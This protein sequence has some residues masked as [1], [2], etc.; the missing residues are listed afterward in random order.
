MY[1]FKVLVY[2]RNPWPVNFITSLL[3]QTPDGEN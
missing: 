2:N 1:K 3:A